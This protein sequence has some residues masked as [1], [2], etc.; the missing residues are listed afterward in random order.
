MNY[1]STKI[2]TEVLSIQGFD[3]R[4]VA[5]CIITKNGER[6][7]WKYEAFRDLQKNTESIS[8]KKL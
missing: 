2:T 5:E 7:K 3:Y 1:Y 4:Y 8:F 6:E